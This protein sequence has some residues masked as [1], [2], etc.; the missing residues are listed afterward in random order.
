LNRKIAMIPT[1][2]NSTLSS[3]QLLA[4]TGAAALAAAL[5][6]VVAVLPAEYGIDPTGIGKRLGL[7][8]MARTAEAP[9]QSTAVR[10]RLDTLKAQAVAVFGAQSGQSFDASAAVRGAGAPKTEAMTV[11]LPPGYGVEVKAQLAAG[12]SLVYHWRATGDVSVDMHGERPGAKDEFTSYLV[13]GARREDAGSFTAPFAGAHGWYWLNKGSQRV[14][15][16]VSVTGFQTKL[17]IPG[18]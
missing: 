10:E 4:A 12:D 1:D 11:M 3:R 2:P 7:L 6:L 14:D 17:F 13:D 18:P 9:A 16:T 15:V 8:A 5:L